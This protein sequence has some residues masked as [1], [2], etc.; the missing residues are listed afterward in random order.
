MFSLKNFS[1]IVVLGENPK[2][3]NLITAYH[4]EKSHKREKLKKEFEAFSRQKKEGSA[5]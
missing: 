1:Y 3:Y 2:G 5:L 4:V